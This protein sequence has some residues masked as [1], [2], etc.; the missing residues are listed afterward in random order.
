LG[1]ADFLGP[2][3]VDLLARVGA[4]DGRTGM[5]LSR[6]FPATRRGGWFRHVIGPNLHS[7]WRET[8]QCAF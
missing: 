4:P 6:F 7:K 5:K 3:L 2:D 1:A 8:N